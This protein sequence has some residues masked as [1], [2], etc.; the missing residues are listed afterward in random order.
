MCFLENPEMGG[1]QLCKHLRRKYDCRPCADRTCRHQILLFDCHDCRGSVWCEHRIRRLNCYSCS[2]R[3]C[4]SCQLWVVKEKDEDGRRRCSY[5]SPYGRYN[6]QHQGKQVHSSEA[7]VGQLMMRYLSQDWTLYPVGTFAPFR[8]CGDNQ[9][10]D[11]VLS[12]SSGLWCDVEVDEEAHTRSFTPGFYSN[13]CEMK[14]VL[15]HSQSLLSSE[16]CESAACIRINPDTWTVAGRVIERSLEERV[17]ILVA[18]LHQLVSEKSAR[19]RLFFL[20]YPAADGLTAEV[21]EMPQ[22]EL[23]EWYSLLTDETP[24]KIAESSITNHAI[25]SRPFSLEVPQDFLNTRFLSTE[26][27]TLPQLKWSTDRKGKG[28][29]VDPRQAAMFSSY[30]TK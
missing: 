19:N 2:P 7:L 8:A 9:K 6:R 11:Y 5:C 29:Q 30:F 4:D 23:L 10:P 15:A 17:R 3:K 21:R 1:S 22:S 20:F 18:H 13:S 28:K 16:G 25:N 26:S 27:A 24:S 14:K 12:H